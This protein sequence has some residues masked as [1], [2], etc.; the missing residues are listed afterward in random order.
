MPDSPEVQ[1]NF[2]APVY[3]VAGKVAG[4]QIIYASPQ[5]QDLAEAAAEIQRLLK[6]L[7]E[8]NPTATE[9][10]KEAYINAAVSTPV[11]KRLLGAVTSGGKAALE[12]FLD[13]PYLNVTMAL[14]EGWKTAE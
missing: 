14:I 1:Q 2:N 5:K 7:E 11:R 12:E 3:G 8:T 9:K 6:Q 4:D 10:Q 13:N